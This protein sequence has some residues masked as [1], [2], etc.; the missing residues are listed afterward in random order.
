MQIDMEGSGSPLV[1]VHS[2]LTDS[3]AFDIVALDLSRRHRVIRVSLPGFGT[4]PRL[5][6]ESP[7]IFDI[8]DVVADALVEAEAGPS[9]AVLGN[10]LG[11][12]VCLA[13]AS[14]H[15]DEFGPLVI[16]NGGVAFSEVQRGAFTTMS[17]LVVKGGMDAVVDVAVKRIFPEAY[18]AVHPNVV[19]ER[20]EVLVKTDPIAFAASCRALR[21]MDLSI[22]AAAIDKPTLVLAGGADQTTPPEMARA[23]ATI[24]PQAHYVEL[25]DC[26]HCPQLERP[27]DFVSAIESFLGRVPSPHY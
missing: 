26:G 9:A 27:D 16:A 18:L 19:S 10:G 14:S 2:L 25:A 21:D 5:D 1:L 11:A 24:L 3:R 23:L 22:D 6:L 17:D 7:S 13:M 8:A 4:T 20:R 15:G 12:F